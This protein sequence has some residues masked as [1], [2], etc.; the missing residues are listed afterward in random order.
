MSEN[1]ITNVVRVGIDI[2]KT[3]FQVHG[4]DRNGKVLVQNKIS[5]HKLLQFTCQMPPCL[6]GMEACGGSHFWAKEFEKQGHTVRLMAGHRVKPYVVGGN[7]DDKVDAAAICEAVGRPAMIFV[8]C[9]S[10]RQLE[11]QA[12]HRHREQLTKLVNVLSN[13]MRGLLLEHGLIIPKGVEHI[14][15]KIPGYL[16]DAENGLSMTMRDL[17]Q[18]IFKQFRETGLRLADVNTTIE[19]FCKEDEICQRICKI[20][21]IGP[22]TA[23]ALYAAIGNGRQFKNGRGAAAWIGIV[24]HHKGSGG[25]TIN[26]KL[27]RRGNRYIKTL[28]IQ[29]GRSVVLAS[30]KKTDARSIGINALQHRKGNNIT[31]VACA[32]RNIRIAWALMARNQEYKKAA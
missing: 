25:K 28:L 27:S 24:P 3:V 13:Q 30:K 14:A 1:K 32:H 26:G 22:I 4:V 20:S 2:A 7:K 18:S 12:L 19:Q 21:G 16:E 6:I 5:R 29:G 8:Q 10:N 31:A 23:T 11:V 15:R 17:I 9:K